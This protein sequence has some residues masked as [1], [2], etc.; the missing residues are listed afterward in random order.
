MHILKRKKQK[1]TQEVSN[2]PSPALCLQGLKLLGAPP[3]NSEELGLKSGTTTCVTEGWSLN[4]SQSPSPHLRRGTKNTHSIGFPGRA[5]WSNVCKELSMVPGSADCT[6]AASTVAWK[7]THRGCL[8]V[9]FRN[10]RQLSGHSPICN[11]SYQKRLRICF[12]SLSAP[13]TS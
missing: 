7:E 8:T 10:Y 6:L 4:F 12:P 5:P 11:S 1:L 13:M 2:S 9:Y 3:Q